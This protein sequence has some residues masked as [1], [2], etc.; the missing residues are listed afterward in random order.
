[1]ACVRVLAIIVERRK[2]RRVASF[3]VFLEIAGSSLFNTEFFFDVK[4]SEITMILIALVIYQGWL[5]ILF[6]IE[7]YLSPVE[8]C[9]CSTFGFLPSSGG[10]NQACKK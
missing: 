4:L 6:A 10:S 8:F 1:M 7:I 2:G 9:K 5:N 3:I